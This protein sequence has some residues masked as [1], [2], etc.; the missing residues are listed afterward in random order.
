LSAAE[1]SHAI[2]GDGSVVGFAAYQ[3]DMGDGSIEHQVYVAPR[4]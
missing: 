2:S 1:N 3:T 4:P